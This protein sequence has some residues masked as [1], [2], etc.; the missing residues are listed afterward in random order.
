MAWWDTVSGWFSDSGSSS[1]NSN[2]WGGIIS[3]IGSAASGYLGSKSKDKDIAA[4]ERMVA[5]KGYE[6]RLSMQFA[7]QLQ[8]YD[9]QLERSRNRAALNT[10]GQFNL[11]DKIMPTTSTP[12]QVPQMPQVNTGGIV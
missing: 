3:G 7:Q 9:R 11:M 12:V 6:D 5:Q 8:D 4:N 2:I 1:G 10:Y